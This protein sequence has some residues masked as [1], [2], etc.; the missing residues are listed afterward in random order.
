MKI[1][2]DD[3]VRLILLLI[4]SAIDILS[5]KQKRFTAEEKSVRKV[6]KKF[7]KLDF[8]SFFADHGYNIKVGKIIERSKNVPIRK[9]RLVQKF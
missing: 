7:L 2:N 9:N 6:A 4:K 5:E 1:N 3:S 8:D